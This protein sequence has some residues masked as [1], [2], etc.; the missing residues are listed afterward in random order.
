MRQLQPQFMDAGEAL[1]RHRSRHIWLLPPLRRLRAG[2]QTEY[3]RATYAD[4]GLA[5]I[6]QGLSDEQVV[7]LT[8]IFPTGYQAAEYCAIK[9]GDTVA[10]WGCGPVGLLAMKSATH[11]GAGKVIGIDRFADRLEM[12]RIECSAEVINYEEQDVAEELHNRTGGRGP[13]S[14]IDAVG[15]EAQ[16]TGMEGAYDTIKQTL[17]LETDR[18]SAL[19]QLIK[20]CRKGGTISVPGVY[21]GFIDKMPIGSIFAKGLT[22]RTGQTHVH[23]YLRPLLDIVESRQ[24]DP[25]FIITHRLALDDAPA[26]Y[27]LFKNKQDG[28]IKIVIKPAAPSQLAAQA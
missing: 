1:R 18:P 20:S 27:D 3:V 25:S 21:G 26:G 8:D 19:R 10:V 16:G 23:R 6:P 24:I 4:V 7:F 28:C 14:C 15:M 5:K 9:P 22:M 12:A 13:G 11:L 17:R 2:G